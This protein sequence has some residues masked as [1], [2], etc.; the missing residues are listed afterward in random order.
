MIAYEKLGV[1]YMGR[2]FDMDSGRLTEELV[3]YDSKDLTTHAVIIGMTGSG[4]TGLGV[5]LIEEALIDN[6][7]V[8]AIDPKGDLPNLL[9]TFPNLS[10][11]DFQ[12]WV[13]DQEALAAGLTRRQ[14]AARQADLWRKGLAD[15]GQGP[16]RIGRLRA[17]ADLAV[18]TPGSRSGLPINTLG[19]FDPPPPAVLEDRD[20]MR[21]RVQSTATSL[22]A[23]VGIEADP[24]G[25]REH[26][27]LANLFNTLWSENKS[28]DLPGLV[29]AI[30][31][32]PFARVG[33]MDLDSIFPARER[34]QLAMRFNNLLASPGFESW[35]EGDPL[36]IQRLLYTAEG[37]PRASIFTLSHLGDAERM[38]FVARLLNEVLAWV[39]SQPG[40]SSLRAILYMDEIFGFFPPV[41]TPPS[42]LPLLTLLKQARA[43]GLGVVLATQNPVDLDYKGLSNTGSWFIGRLQ[44]EGDKQ[45]VM[46]GLEGA[47]GGG[48]FDRGR[49]ERVLAG[50]GKRVFLL[51]NVHENAPVTF[52]TRWTLSYLRGPMT[53]EQIK[54]LT[55]AAAPVG[56]GSAPAAAGIPAPAAGAGLESRPPILPP[57]IDAHYLPVSGSAA[58]IEYY[59]AVFG[60]LTAH[61]AQAKYQVDLARRVSFA[62]P[63]ADGPVALD[64]N[65]AIEI[66][67]AP[68][69]F[70]KAPA[71]GAAFAELPAEAKKVT[72][73]EG[74]RRDLLQWVRRNHALRLMNS[75]RFRLVSSPQESLSEFAARVS[76]AAREQR[77]LE[78]EKLRRRYA[79]KF[80]TL[81]DRLMR[82]EQATMREKEQ[83]SAKK[84]ETAI[85]FGTA[86]LGAFLGRKA[87]SAT[88]AGRLGTAM[89]SAGRLRKESMDTARAQQTAES[90]RAKIAELEAELEADIAKLEAAFDPAGESFKEIRIPPAPAGITQ[91]FFG[92][93]W[94]PYR[95]DDKG[96]AVPAWGAASQ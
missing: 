6:I 78:V 31:Q 23:L 33:V 75:E 54:T 24:V 90:V 76:Q 20:L 9:L 61:Y 12:P 62:A 36:D 34:F 13:D 30:Q 77:D 80:A 79:G 65:Q 50:L 66:P 38:F 43:F 21:E 57:G 8:I 58:G 3:L 81:Q 4:K 48:S 28:L 29:H 7:P 37:K 22:L 2:K 42:K 64:W 46:A 5:G 14:F 51:N 95:R 82:S 87:V 67:L 40:T 59:P 11:D 91:E 85:S 93:L 47:A 35:L 19:S 60:G 17:A 1:F 41:R 32:P 73:Y 74:W 92:L 83:L 94:L 52:Q 63:L 44:T 27:L 72:A 53:R 45:R 96:K 49:M 84:V 26:I 89:K 10:A 16:E 56:Y 69:E 70:V 18:Y 88:S 55:A 71:A 86:I 15:W 68:R 39:R 25:S